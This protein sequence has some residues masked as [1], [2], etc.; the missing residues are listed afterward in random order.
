MKSRRSPCTR[1]SLQQR[2]NTRARVDSVETVNIQPG[3]VY[4]TPRGDPGIRV[5]NFTENIAA[6]HVYTL[7]QHVKFDCP[8][9]L[10]I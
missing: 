8:G 3:N 1:T 5:G 7:L 4:S 10:Y 2:Q 9:E 6:V